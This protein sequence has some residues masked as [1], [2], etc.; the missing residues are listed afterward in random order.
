[1]AHGLRADLF[2]AVGTSS[3]AHPAAGLAEGAPANGALVIEINSNQTQ[4]ADFH[5]S[6]PSRKWLPAVARRVE[7]SVSSAD[8]LNA[9]DS[10]SH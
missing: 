1:V 10:R 6:G 9:R 3:R 8:E 5:L 7:D 2:L 4:Q